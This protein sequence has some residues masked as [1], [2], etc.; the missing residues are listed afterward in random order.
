MA[1]PSLFSIDDD[2]T[3]QGYEGVAAQVLKFKLRSTV[4]VRSAQLQVWDADAFNPELGDILENPPRS[5]PSAPAL[6]LSNGTATGQAVDFSPLSGEITCTLPSGVTASWLVR[7]VINGGQRVVNGVV[8][9]DP[10]LIHERMVVIRSGAGLRQLVA[11]ETRQQSDDGVAKWGEEVLA[12][13]G[14]VATSSAGDWK[15]SVR[16]ATTASLPAYNRVGN[17]ITG[18]ANGTVP[19]ATTDSTATQAGD[20]VLLLH[21]AAPEDNGIYDVTQAGVAGGGGSPFVWTRAEDAD[22][23]AKVTP[24]MRVPVEEGTINAAKVFKLTTTGAIV[25]N[26]TGLTFSR[27]NDLPN[28]SIVDQ[29][30]KWNGSSWIAGALNLAAAA[31]VTGLLPLAN[32]ATGGAGTVLIGGATPSYSATPTVTSLAATYI[33]LGADPADAGAIRLSHAM[34]VYGESNTPGTDRAVLTWGVTANDTVNLG[35]AGTVTRVTGSA[36]HAYAGATQVAQLGVAT[37]DYLKLGDVVASTGYVRFDDSWSIYQRNTLNTFDRRVL[38]GT[39]EAWILGDT[40]QTG[41]G[42]INSTTLQIQAGIAAYIDAN[43]I[44]CRPSGAA[45]NGISITG[46]TGTINVEYSVATPTISQTTHA[47]TP[48]D[49][50]IQAQHVTT[51]TGSNLN[52][53]SGTGSVASGITRLYAGSTL[54][55][56][57]ENGGNVSLFAAGSFGGGVK[58]LFGADATTE[59]TSDPVGG[60]LVWWYNGAFKG[61]GTSGT[62][63][64]IAAAEPHCPKCGNDYV[65]EARNPDRGHHVAICWTC[66]LDTCTRHGIERSDFAFIDQLGKAA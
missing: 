65:F 55:L 10:N 9:R 56:S 23:S 31:A 60:G 2:L 8:V 44:Y 14:S 34:G 54:A 28:G 35:D 12:A 41:I 38:S 16:V 30:A 4:G 59:P 25:L 36:L 27:E 5:S 15:P 40:A 49:F 64:T 61:R 19:S 24:G 47:T 3:D 48:H 20:R 6:T 22:T 66:F 18:T 63:T 11:T 21:G 33:A 37:T 50:T 17:V 46:S 58:V 13:L 26:T 45:N 7:C 1:K 32:L 39:G 43:V 52:L 42:V 29:I 53:K 57:A 51:G 62:I